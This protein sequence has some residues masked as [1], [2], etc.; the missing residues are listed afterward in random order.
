MVDAHET[1]VL[2]RLGAEEYGVPVDA[3]TAVIRP[4]A[5]TP[6]PGSPS[7]CR[8]VINHRGSVIPVVDMRLRFGMGEP[9][10]APAH[11]LVLETVD[12]AV[13]LLADRVS[14]VL[15]VETAAVQPAP[16]DIGGSRP[17]GV[18]GLANLGKRLVVLLDVASL[19]GE[20]LGAARGAGP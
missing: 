16:P 18:R 17:D 1:F 7:F 11:L 6:L 20:E 5:P 12:G 2:F 4:V 14:E 3:A 19:A 9:T 15:E 8:G 10:T 13:G